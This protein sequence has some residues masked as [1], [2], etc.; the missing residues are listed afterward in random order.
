MRDFLQ[1]RDNSRHR[2]DDVLASDFLNRPFDFHN[3]SPV[4]FLRQDPLKCRLDKALAHL[5][6]HRTEYEHDKTWDVERIF[7]SLNTGWE[8]FLTLLPADRRNWFLTEFD[9][10]A[11][12]D[13]HAWL[14]NRPEVNR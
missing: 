5:S 9:D 8:H 3:A 1:E 6:Y 7:V 11:F 4:S 2:K 10:C 14:A 12:D 13:L